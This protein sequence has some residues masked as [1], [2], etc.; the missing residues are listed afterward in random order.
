M[1]E[2]LELPGHD[3]Q[4]DQNSVRAFCVKGSLQAEQQDPRP[5]DR[6]VALHGRSPRPRPAW[7]VPQQGP[8]DE[9]LVSPLHCCVCSVLSLNSLIFKVYT[10]DFIC[11]RL[12]NASV[13]LRCLPP[14]SASLQR[15]GC[16]LGLRRRSSKLRRGFCKLLTWKVDKNLKTKGQ[17][18]D[19]NATSM[20]CQWQASLFHACQA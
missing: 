10:A 17:E 14:A 3:S 15:R 6:I 7:R 18:H 4:Q 8:V 1:P 12:R 11:C 13:G 9:E 19:R 20:L 5:A 2:A 16:C